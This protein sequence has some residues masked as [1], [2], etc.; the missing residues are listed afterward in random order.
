MVAETKQFCRECN[1][2]LYPKEDK[3]EKMLYLACRNCEHF[4]EAITPTVY[5]AEYKKSTGK[6]AMEM[7]AKEIAS[8]PTL[9]RISKECSRCNHGVHAVFQPKDNREDE[10]LSVNY[11]CCRCFKISNSLDGVFS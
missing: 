3:L 4:E 6:V 2:M 1:N 5:T 10:P 7:A 9:K 11:A 8:D